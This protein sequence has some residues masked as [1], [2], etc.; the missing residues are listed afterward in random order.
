MSFFFNNCSRN[1]VLRRKRIPTNNITMIAKLKRITIIV[2][3][4]NTTNAFLIAIPLTDQH[5]IA[6]HTA[7]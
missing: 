2:K 7:I 1:V 3:G 4:G 6:M 5:S